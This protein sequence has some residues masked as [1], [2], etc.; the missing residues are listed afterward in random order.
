MPVKIQL[1]L[2]RQIAWPTTYHT[3]L[4]PV[5]FY[6]TSLSLVVFASLRGIL[7]DSE[8]KLEINF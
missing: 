3:K 6:E 8:A 1:P 7:G 5:T 4:L 2:E